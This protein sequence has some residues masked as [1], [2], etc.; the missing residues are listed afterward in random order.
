MVICQLR[1]RSKDVRR[2]WSCFRWERTGRRASERVNRCRYSIEVQLTN[3]I[4]HSRS[5][6][7]HRNKANCF[8]ISLSQQDQQGARKVYVPSVLLSNVMSL[9]PKLDEVS[10]AITNA[11]LDIACITET[12]LC[13]HIHD[14]VISIPGYNLVRRDRI[15]VIH[16][17]VCTYIK[18][19]LKYTVLEDLYDDKIEAIWLQLPPSHLPRGISCIIMTIVYHPQTDKGVSDPE[20]LHYLYDSMSTIESRFSN[21]GVLIIGDFNRLDTSR[22]RN[23]FKLKQTV[24]FH[25]RGN[26][27]LDLVLT[28]IEKFYEEPIKRP[29]FG[30][31]DHA[32][33]EI[34]PLSRCKTQPSKR[35]IITR[36]Q[37]ESYR[38]ALSSYLEK[39]NITDLVKNKD[40]CD[41]KMQM[42]EKLLFPVWTQLCP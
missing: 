21:C 17:G 27:T 39:V 16:G 32:S 41:E 33:V 25:T 36:E 3:R 26:Q 24:K 38:V 7:R 30:L 28:N 6:R 22:F 37:R 4:N 14:N 35:S 2:V 11:N 34:Q 31:S 42:M 13:D 9:A 5:S 19:G 15:D 23:A 18:K 1:S 12:W 40:T 8:T 10:D 20:I 29:A